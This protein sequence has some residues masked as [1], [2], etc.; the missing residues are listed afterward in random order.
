MSFMKNIGNV[1]KKASVVIGTM[2]DFV[3]G[4]GEYKVYESVKEYLI[5]KRPEMKMLDLDEY[6]YK[7]IYAPMQSGKTSMIMYKAIE[8]IMEGKNVVIVVRNFIVDIIQIERRFNDE[9]KRINNL[10]NEGIIKGKKVKGQV[11][12][13][14]DIRNDDLVEDDNQGKIILMMGSNHQYEKMD[15]KI[16][17][18]IENGDSLREMVMMID[19][20]DVQIKSKGSKLGKKLFRNEHWNVIQ[21]VGVTATTLGS[22]LSNCRLKGQQVVMLLPSNLYKGVENLSSSNAIKSP[23]ENDVLSSDTIQVYDNIAWTEN[24]FDDKNGKSHP[25]IILNKTETYKS[26]QNDIAEY[27]YDRYSYETI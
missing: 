18:V 26:K 6:V 13:V 15:N 12:K 11:L 9:I 4:E 20:V 19:E 8:H 14:N 1:I 17:S 24:K 3:S 23:K 7:M 16:D 22:M 10:V 21:R 25:V 2:G 5:S 27:L